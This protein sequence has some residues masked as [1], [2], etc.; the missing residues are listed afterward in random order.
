MPCSTSSSLASSSRSSTYFTVWITCPAILKSPKPSGVS[1]VKYSLCKSGRIG[2]KQ[3]P[4]SL[5]SPS[6]TLVKFYFNTLLH[7]QF[8]DQPSFMSVPVCFRIWISLVSFHGHM[9]S[10]GLWSGRTVPLCPNYALILFFSIPITSVVSCPFL[11]PDW[12][13]PGTSLIFLLILLLST[14][15]TVSAVCAD[16]VMVTAFCSCWL[17]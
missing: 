15:T 10:A 16:H 3:P 7:V 12:S 2:D 11:N 8:A 5:H 6:F 1:L 4:S 14:F 13:S 9:P 17:L